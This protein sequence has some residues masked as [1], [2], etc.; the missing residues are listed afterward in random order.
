VVGRASGAALATM[1]EAFEDLVFLGLDRLPR[2]GE[3]IKTSAF[4]RTVGGGAVITAVAAARLGL[5]TEVWSGLGDEAALRLDAEQVAVTNLR[6]PREP[7]AI[8]AALSTRDERSFV[9]FNGINDRLEARLLDA[10]PRLRARHVHFAF[11]PAECSVWERAVERLR[12]RGLTTSW[13]FGWNE[14]LLHDGGFPALVRAL[15]L[16]FFNELEA[17][18]YARRD[19]LEEALAAWRASERAVIVKL[20][21]AGS[22]WLSR[23][24]D[25]HAPAPR[26]KVLDTTG[27]GDAFNGGFLVGWLHGVR[28]AGC[29]RL[30]N[31]VGARSTRAAGG[32]DAL[33][34][35]SD[36]PAAL[37]RLLEGSAP[38][39][40]LSSV[41]PRRGRRR[42]PPGGSS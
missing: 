35:L 8:T 31:V 37:R 16:V 30:G 9:T 12:A 15:D 42:G 11:F 14:A 39:R 23:G 33:P 38:P 40:P 4:V 26:V 36:V 10:L 41:R 19:T 20:G 24:T 6:R 1:G 18:L 17:R 7:H 27:A 29:L 28:P 2:P 32:L 13:D 25:V 34:A 3:E 21:A 5:A 22:R